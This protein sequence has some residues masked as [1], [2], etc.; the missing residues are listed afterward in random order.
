[1]TWKFRIAIVTTS[2]MAATAA[3]LKIFSCYMLPNGRL[4]GAGQYGIRAIWQSRIAKN[5]SVLISKMATMA[6][7]LKS[8]NHICS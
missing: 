1:M 3:I 6:A 8:S 4:D 7:I 2:K 5:G